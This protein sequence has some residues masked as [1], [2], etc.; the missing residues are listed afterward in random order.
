MCDSEGV[1]LPDVSKRQ[2]LWV[3]YLETFIG[4]G[5]Y[6][7]ILDAP[8]RV[9]TSTTAI[10]YAGGDFENVSLRQSAEMKLIFLQKLELMILRLVDGRNKKPP[11][12]EAFI[13]SRP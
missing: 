11:V 10:S 3:V 13:I 6:G 9:S 4:W 12:W 1:L 7:L 5:L 2:L 8:R